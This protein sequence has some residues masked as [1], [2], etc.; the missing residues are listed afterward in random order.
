[1]NVFIIFT[2]IVITLVIT[3]IVLKPSSE[4]NNVIRI[5]YFA[6]INHA[7]AI[8]AI[9]NNTFTNKLDEI[10]YKVEYVRFNAGTEAIQALLSRK[11][12]LTYTGPVPAIIG[13]TMS[14]NEIKIIAGSASG[15]SLFIVRDDLNIN[16]PL[17]LMNKRLATP[18]YGNTQDIALRSYIKEHGLVPKEFGGNVNI[19]YVKGPE[20]LILFAK[21]ELDGIW[22]P[23]PWA[24]LVLKKSNSKIF[25]D[26]K[27][28]WPDN[29]FSTT[30]LVTRDD[31]IKEHSEALKK[32]LEAHKETT[33]WLNNNKDKSIPII[34]RYLEQETKE[35]FD[36]DIIKE[37]L[38]N[39]EFTIDPIPYSINE[40]G[41]K[42]Y[43]LRIINKIPNSKDIL[44]LN[45]TK[46]Q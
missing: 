40:Y 7:Q 29:K 5:G 31:F 30:V 14:N 45:L 43:E 34:Q 8:I 2:I 4:S 19:L 35:K 1:M 11:I 36:Y 25:L 13:N 37:A 27:E 28:L 32:I 9:A 18:D 10:G 44:Y 3:I 23:Q 39:I 42:A 24:T 20:A 41:R 22:L 17:D 12:D 26:E 16:E 6:N 33:D 21:K 38:Y 15:G 46:V